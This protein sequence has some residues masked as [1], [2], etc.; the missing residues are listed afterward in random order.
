MLKNNSFLGYSLD[1]D[2]P[3]PDDIAISVNHVIGKLLIQ[4]SSNINLVDIDTGQIIDIIPGQYFYEIQ[5]AIFINDDLILT[6]SS[7]D[8]SLEIWDSH[9]LEIL[10]VFNT[11][12]KNNIFVINNDILAIGSGEG[13]IKIYTAKDL[14]YREFLT[15]DRYAMNFRYMTEKFQR[16][17]RTFLLCR[18]RQLNNG[19]GVLANLPMEVCL[20]ILVF[21]S[22]APFNN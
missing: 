17:V 5:K 9:R 14:P 13:L 7:G 21:A 3:L 10:K 6:C 4:D 8:Y 12:N 15:F 19:K 20:H 2:I 16:L 1:N 11:G 18:Q 22:W